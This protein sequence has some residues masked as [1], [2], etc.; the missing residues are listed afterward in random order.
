MPPSF[1]HCWLLPRLPDLMAELPG[2]DIRVNAQGPH[3]QGDRLPFPLLAD[4][5]ADVQIVYGDHN[6]WEDRAALLLSEVFQPY[7]APDFLAQHTL[8]I[9]DHL[10][11]Q[12]LISVSQNPVSWEEWLNSHGV[13]LHQTSVGGIQLDPSHLAIEAA[14][15]GLGV[16]LES[17]V[18]VDRNVSS[19]TLVSPF[20]DLGRSGLSYWMYKPS[21]KRARPAVEAVMAWLGENAVVELIR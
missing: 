8:D 16:I 9:P 7:C 10:L 12:T 3:L 13:D 2:I 21:A 1:A 14:V 15:K 20:P 6:I 19:G 11:E 17:S 5:P 4:A 18:L